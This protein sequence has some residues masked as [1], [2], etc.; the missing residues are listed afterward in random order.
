MIERVRKANGGGAYFNAPATDVKFF[1]TGC[2]V[3]DLALGGGWAENRIANIIGDRS[4]GKTLLAIEAAINFARKYPKGKIRYREAEAAF[5]Q[6]Y[7]K[8]LGM[9]LHR[10]DFG[11]QPL[12][13]I[14][15]LFE[16]L[17]YSVKHNREPELYI[18]DSLD[19]LSDRSE[20]KRQ[21]DEGT[22][23][24]EKAKKL[25]QLFRRLVRGMA[26]VNITLII[27]S[28]VR[29]K[30]G[31]TFGRKWTRSGG[32]ALDFYTSQVLVLAPL[33]TI[34]RTVNGI[35]RAVG[36]E[37]KAKVDKLKV[38]GSPFREAQF[39]ISFTYGIDDVWACLSWL[40]EVG[41]LSELQLTEKTIKNYAK[42]LTEKPNA[43]EIK[44]L[45]KV[46]QNQWYRVEASFRPK[47]GKYE[48]SVN[49]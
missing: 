26:N 7:A 38:G 18:C 46:V 36:I 35:K 17:D 1:S 14:E 30:I 21:M 12:E 48:S 47:R 40:K 32:R 33:G 9:P 16:D 13:T 43:E 8:A 23:G 4:T 27:I 41:A 10:V 19:A 29:S 49:P 39:E 24:A 20:L 2:K 45:H 22:Y 37:V 15:D 25:S 31:V 42:D 5:D 6:G 11:K 28:Q 34:S 3:L 44:H